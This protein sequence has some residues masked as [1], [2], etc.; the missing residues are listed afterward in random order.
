MSALE[1]FLQFD[2][3]IIDQMPILIQFTVEHVMKNPKSTVVHCCPTVQS[4]LYSLSTLKP[5]IKI[6]NNVSQSDIEI[7]ALCF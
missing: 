6:S 1:A 5:K 4:L 3:P 7:I 2:Q